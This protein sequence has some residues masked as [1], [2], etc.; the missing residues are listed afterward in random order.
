VVFAEYDLD[1]LTLAAQLGLTQRLLDF[2]GITSV[3]QFDS[4]EILAYRAEVDTLDLMD[5]EDPPFYVQND[6]EPATAPTTVNLLYHHANHALVLAEQADGIGLESVAYIKAL[7][8]ADPSGED[9]FEFSLRH[10]G[11]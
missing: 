1:V 6:L 10:L 8:I 7:G 5:P 4:P 3:E 2:Y 9:S 11:L